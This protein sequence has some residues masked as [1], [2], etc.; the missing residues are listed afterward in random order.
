MTATER[1]DSER[2]DPRRPVDY[3]PMH[4]LQNDDS[5]CAVFQE[6]GHF[7]LQRWFHLM[8]RDDLKV[9]P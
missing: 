9:I 4:N 8:F 1:D 7:L 2:S 5:L 3:S 6:V